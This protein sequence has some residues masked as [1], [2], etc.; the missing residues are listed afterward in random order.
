MSNVSGTG[1]S[2]LHRF[3]CDTNSTET[4]YYQPESSSNRNGPILLL[5]KNIHTCA[6][7]LA[8]GNLCRVCGRLSSKLDVHVHTKLL[9]FSK[10]HIRTISHF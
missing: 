2:R 3:Y 7:L 9:V 1:Y 5:P 8:C 4:V 6:S 10:F